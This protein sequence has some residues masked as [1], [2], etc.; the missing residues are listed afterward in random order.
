[1]RVLMMSD[2]S[3]FGEGLSALLSECSE[4]E[5]M[6]QMAVTGNGGLSDQIEQLRPDVLVLD[7]PEDEGPSPALVHCL[8][9]G[10]VRK[11]VTVNSQDNVVCV[12][13]SE[14]HVIDEVGNLVEAITGGA[15]GR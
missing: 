15:Q 12:F 14:R 10:W 8:K 3:I 7:C 13:T 1:V 9:N 2:N 5:V 6:G 11:I 4:F